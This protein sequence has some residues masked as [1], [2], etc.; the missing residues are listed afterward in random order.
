MQVQSLGQ[1][2]SPAAHIGCGCGCAFL[3]FGAV[4]VSGISPG[5]T[6]L[7]HG[8]GFLGLSGL[9]WSAALLGLAAVKMKLVQTGIITIQREVVRIMLSI[10]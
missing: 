2:D 9:G 4:A 6:I 1:E 10:Y 8:G 7:R 3:Y 5:L